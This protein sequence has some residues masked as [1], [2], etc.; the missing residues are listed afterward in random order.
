MRA[1]V[2]PEYDMFT[3]FFTNSTND[4][5]HAIHHVFVTMAFAAVGDV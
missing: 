1:I 3:V 4:V 2:D 5:H